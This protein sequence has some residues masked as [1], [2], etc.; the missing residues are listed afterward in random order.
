MLLEVLSTMN[1]AFPRSLALLDTALSIVRATGPIAGLSLPT[2]AI[3][4]AQ[5]TPHRTREA[6]LWL[7][8]LDLSLSELLSLWQLRPVVVIRRAMDRLQAPPRVGGPLRRQA[9]RVQH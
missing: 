1:R 7:R 6:P 8:N 2:R 3:L 4:R 5:T 9:T